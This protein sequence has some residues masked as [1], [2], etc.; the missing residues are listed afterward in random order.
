[1][2]EVV[3]VADFKASVQ[4]DDDGTWLITRSYLNG[5]K[6]GWKATWLALYPQPRTASRCPEYG[7]TP[8]DPVPLPLHAS[9]VCP[10]ASQTE[11]AG[12]S[13]R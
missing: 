12:G 9:V 13:D 6:V 2:P 4:G 10:N 5:R 8:S 3:G 7:C 1:M 11:P